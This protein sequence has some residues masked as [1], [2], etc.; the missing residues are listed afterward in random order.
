MQSVQNHACEELADDGQKRDSPVVVTVAPVTLIPVEGDDLGIS[1]VLWY[2][3]L[4]P[5]LAKDVM[6]RL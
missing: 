4:S 5:T 1:H 2:S 3:S 6:K